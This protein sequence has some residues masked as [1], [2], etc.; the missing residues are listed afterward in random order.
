MPDPTL[1]TDRVQPAWQDL[2]PEQ[3]TCWHFWAAANPQVD[4]T[5][6]LQTLYGQ[7]AHYQRNAALAVIDEDLQLT[8]PPTS[9]TPPEPITITAAVWP[10]QALL[11]DDTTAR[12]GTAA[13]ILRN[14]LPSTRGA[15]VT[16]TY[17]TKKKPRGRPPRVRHVLIIDSGTPTTID[18]SIPDGYFATTA[19]ANRFARI[20]GRTARR[21]PDLPF[22]KVRVI[23]LQTGAVTRQPINNPYGGAR[24]SANRARATSVDPQPG[25]HYP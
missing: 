11:P 1:L 18:P 12:R 2:T 20:L 17:D 10:N 14:S 8:D 5:G 22:G 9:N 4:S 3:R 13:L 15:I 24:T 19:G 21:R 16:Q 23:D 6:E 7:Q 25:D